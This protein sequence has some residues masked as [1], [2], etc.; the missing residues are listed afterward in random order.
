MNR[1]FAL[2]TTL[3]VSWLLVTPTFAAT[4]YNN[5]TPNNLMGRFATRCQ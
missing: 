1:G 5:L 3:G 2:F 4:I